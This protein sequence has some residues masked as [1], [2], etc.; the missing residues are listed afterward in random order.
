VTAAGLP[1][2]LPPVLAGPAHADALAAL[3]AAC[4]PPGEQWPSVAMAAQLALPGCFGLIGLA[5]PDAPG[6]LVLARVAA[7]EAEILTLGVVPAQRRRGMAA[8]L[9]AQAARAAALRGAGAMFLEVAEDNAA[10]RALYARQGFQE[11]GRRKRY[12]PSGA[13]ALVLRLGLSPGAAT[14]C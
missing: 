4:F 5:G 10:A 13:D 3:H 12:Y 1:D 6:G 8:L 11:V 9:L 7:D 14:A 2:L